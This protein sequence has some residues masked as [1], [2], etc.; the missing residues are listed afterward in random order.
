[1]DSAARCSNCD[2]GYNAPILHMV[3]SLPRRL[4]FLLFL[5][6]LLTLG[7]SSWAGDWSAP[8]GQLAQ[9]LVAVTGPGAV[10]VDFSN[11]SS[12]SKDD[13]DA[14]RRGLLTELAALGLRFV[15]AEQAAAR[16]HI[17]LSENLASYVWVAEIRAGAGEA[18]VVMVSLP[19]PESA[20][21]APGPTQLT[22]RK[23]LLW[24][25]PERILDAA[26][27]EGSPPH[28]L[29]LGATGV[30]LYKLQDSRWQ[31]EQVFPLTHSR[32][33]PRDLRGRLALRKGH[34][35]DAYLPGVFCQSLSSSNMSC[36]ESDDPWPVGTELF[37]LNGFF[38]SA[39]NFFPG[40]L[41]PGIGKQT[42]AP[43][44]YS[45]APLPREKYVLW[46]VAAV[47]GQ[48]HVLD[49]I[50]DQAMSGTGWGSDIA[51]VR[52]SCGLGWQVLATRAGSG[53]DD[54]VQ[55][56]EVADREPAAASSPLE[57]DGAVTAM[58]TEASGTAAIAVSRNSKTGKYDVYR[59]AMACGQ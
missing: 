44:F 35:F 43:A 6:L 25:Q 10:A 5:F 41:T 48:V 2:A 1:M 21:S 16:V 46:L 53:S 40:A 8:Q 11:R 56:F 26:V 59:L 15:Q 32:P 4:P 3:Q 49:G 50:R 18:S 57:F 24:S 38:A 52:S 27:I 12:L 31:P 23:T 22:I 37:S 42:A 14:I 30:S 29:V 28:L 36:R 58:W 34:L 51:T 55:A 9:K 13:F 33:W 19:R 54:M 20:G 7:R 17:F 47:D 45:A 39:R